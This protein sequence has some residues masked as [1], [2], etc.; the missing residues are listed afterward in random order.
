MVH[1]FSL[2]VTCYRNVISVEGRSIALRTDPKQLHHSPCDIFP[3]IRSAREMHRNPVDLCLHK[4][5]NPHK[6]CS[7]A[8]QRLQPTSPPSH[9]WQT[10]RGEYSSPHPTVIHTQHTQ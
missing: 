4:D 2:A 1:I 6:S 9:I 5:S 7:K 3:H 10:L 8:D